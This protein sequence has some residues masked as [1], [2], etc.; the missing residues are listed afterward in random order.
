MTPSHDDDIIC[1]TLKVEV[2]LWGTWLGSKPS[3]CEREVSLIEV[4]QKFVF[5]ENGIGAS[6]VPGLRERQMRE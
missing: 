6:E 2:E 1:Q 4:F 5:D 3:Q